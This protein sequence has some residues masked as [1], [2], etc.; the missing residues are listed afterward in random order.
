M[1]CAAGKQTLG[2]TLLFRRGAWRAAPPGYCDLK[3]SY[4]PHWGRGLACFRRLAEF[5][6]YPSPVGWGPCAF[7]AWLRCVTLARGRGGLACFRRLVRRLGSPSCFRRWGRHRP[8]PMAT[9][10]YEF[11]ACSATWQSL[12]PTPSCA[13]ASCTPLGIRRQATAVH[14]PA[15]TRCRL[16]IRRLMLDTPAVHSPA[17]GR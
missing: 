7:A 3:V 2:S 6:A 11:L 15:G 4:P 1:C 8:S 17:V 14:S 13:F 10:G 5:G 12:E 16:C 9:P